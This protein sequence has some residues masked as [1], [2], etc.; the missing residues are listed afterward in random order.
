[1]VKNVIINGV[2]Y[3][4]VPYVNIP[5]SDGSGNNAK[6]VDTDSGDAAAGD[7]RSGKKVWVDG[8]EITGTVPAKDADDVSISGKTVTVPV[9]I[10]DSQVQ[11]SVADGSVTPNAAV[12]GDEIG[13]ASSDYSITITPKATVGT[14]GYVSTIA[15]GSPVTKYIQVQTKTVSPSDSSQTINPD[16]GKL[17]KEVVVNAVSLSGDAS[18]SDVLNGKTF[19]KDSMTKLTGTAT[20]PVVGQDSTTKVLTI[21]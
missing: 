20:V 1:M 9:G 3:N 18:P 19:Y 16:S 11:K 10:Y 21:Q 15:D 12:S 6:F 17:L 2:T 4:D 13:D 5:L 8:S 7:I 14:A